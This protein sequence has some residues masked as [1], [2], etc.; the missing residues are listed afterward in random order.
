MASKLKGITVEIGGDTTK[1][2]DALKGV[3]S[4]VKS[5]QSELKG[6]NT[7]LKMD[8]SNVTLL[9][10]KQDLLTKSISETE[11]KLK[12]LKDAQAQVQEQFEK[13]E[14]TE[15]QYRDFQREIVATEQKLESLKEEAKNFGSV[16]QQQCENASKK[17]K[18]VGGKIEDV[19]KKMSGLSV[20]AVAVM[21]AS[22]KAFDELDAGYDT[23]ITKTGATGE[24]LEGLTTVADNIFG[25]M[26]TDMETVGVA[27]GEVNTR[28]ALTGDALEELSE[29][30]IQFSEINGVDLNNSIG[31]VDKILE[32]FNMTAEDAGGVLD[33]IT[34]KAQETGISADSLMS[35]VQDNGATFKDMGIG[36]NEAVVL[37]S[38]FEANGVNVET[39]IKGLKKATIE[40]TEEGLSMEE[41]LGETIDSIKNAET[42]TEALAIAQEIF[43]TKGA[44]EMAKAIREGRID[45]D[46]LSASMEEYGGTVSDTFTA[47]LDP[48][49]NAKVGLNNLKLVGAELGGTL[50]T[51]LE[52]IINK[53]VEGLKNLVT[54]FSGL[55][56][57]T[58]TTIVV[59]LGIVASL[60]PLIIVIG[61]VVTAVGSIISIAGKVGTALKTVKTAFSAL[62]AT[63]LANPIGIVIT[64]IVAL[65]AIF[66]TLYKKCDWFREGVDKI[67]KKVKDFFVNGFNSIKTFLTTKV[68]EIINNVTNWFKQ[69]PGKIYDSIK[70]AVNKVSTWGSNLLSTAKSKASAVVSGVISY[71]KQIPSKISSAISGALSVIT[72][73]GSNMLSRAK[74]AV[75][76]VVNG[77]A[78]TFKTVVS[79]VASIGG[80]IVAGVWS[81]ISNKI[82]WI[83]DRIAG[84]K[85][86]VLNA[87]KS[88]FGIASPSKV[89]KAEVGTHIASGVAEGI[90]DSD[91]PVNAINQMNED[92]LRNAQNI[93]GV[94]LRRQ[95]E[96]TFSGTMSPDRTL[97]GRLDAIF[98]KLDKMKV[99]LDTGA[100]VGETVAEYDRALSNIR[101][102]KARG[103]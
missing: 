66:V 31:T 84:F 43:G 54:W 21:G 11:T 102:Q 85:D 101:T 17:V 19:G 87:L 24:A 65:I 98:D 6:V 63:M 99:V 9:K 80:E 45:V 1:L 34:K 37:L 2:G 25:S 32:Q 56:E 71:M 73:W 14:I 60:A 49:D 81:G 69:L 23:I 38:Q 103:W 79:R 83:R 97:L 46:D 35:I 78:T 55:S 29:Q 12:T 62:N 67:M 100:F 95:M 94:T 15:E 20:G 57:T 96:T 47:T 61:K 72:K 30:F 89:M 16:F 86:A 42:E 13:G 82:D 70:G 74:S 75:Q 44:N 22:L 59:V 52:P 28:F 18:D 64:A 27:V 41:A 40:Y 10:Q 3:N 53:I 26:P 76:S 4:N 48:I 5:L 91:E 58:K 77:I 88:V 93:N 33:L 90:I 50:Y 36:V 7:L 39:A 51:S 8:P 68:P 92:I